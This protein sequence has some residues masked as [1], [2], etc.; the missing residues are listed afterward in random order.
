MNIKRI[1]AYGVYYVAFGNVFIYM[2]IR[3]LDY[4]KGYNWKSV[5]TLNFLI[6]FLILPIHNK[7][8]EI[9]DQKTK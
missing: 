7:I 5:M 9:I 6:I 1:L 3:F 2:A 8:E 4:F